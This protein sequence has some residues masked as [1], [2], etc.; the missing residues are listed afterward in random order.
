MF[1]LLNAINKNTIVIF[2]SSLT[3]AERKSLIQSARN[4]FSFAK[5]RFGTGMSFTLGEGNLMF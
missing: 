1:F 3:T 5:S 4:D 2:D